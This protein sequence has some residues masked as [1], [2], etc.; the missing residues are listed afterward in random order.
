LSSGGLVFSVVSVGM[1]PSFSGPWEPEPNLQNNQPH[2]LLAAEPRF[3]NPT[4]Q[5]SRG[6]AAL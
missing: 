5:A 2:Q 6:R 4:S 1:V 3:M